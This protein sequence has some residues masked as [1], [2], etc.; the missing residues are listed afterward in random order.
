[1]T[2]EGKPLFPRIDKTK[3]MDDIK[4]KESAIRSL[5]SEA[6]ETRP[7]GRVQSATDDRRITAQGFGQH[8]TE[9]DAVASI[10]GGTPALPVQKEIGEGLIEITAFAKIVLRVGEVLSAAR[11]P[12]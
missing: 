8:A 6:A 4:N 7:S 1:E 5:A 2:G 3:I 10:A 11:V 12:K 9:A